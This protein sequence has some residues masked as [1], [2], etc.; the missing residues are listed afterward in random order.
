MA[1]LVLL[2]SVLLVL[3]LLLVAVPVGVRVA[4]VALGAIFGVAL[5]VGGSAVAIGLCLYLLSLY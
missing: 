2:V 5:C 4:G 1:E 3:E